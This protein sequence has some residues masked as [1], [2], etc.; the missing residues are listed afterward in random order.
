MSQDS[1]KIESVAAREVLDS[2]G[3]PTVEAEVVLEGGARACGIAPSGASTGSGEAV[4]L[5]DGDPKRFGGKGVTKAV[6][7]ASGA[8]A[9][10]LVGT[11]AGDQVQVD[12]AMIE[13]DGTPDKSRLGANAIL[14]VSI[15]CARAAAAHAGKEPYET[16]AAEPDGPM[17][18]PLM[19]LIN[20]GAHASNALDFQ[21]FM[22]VPHGFAR[23]SDALRAGAEIYRCLGD[24]LSANGLGTTVGDE[25]GYA[26]ALESAEDALRLLE[27]SIGRAGY[28]PGE[29]V[30]LALDCAATE[31]FSGGGYRMGGRRCSSEEMVG[32]LCS[33][34]ER[35]PHLVSIEDGLAED[36]WEGWSL[37]TAKLGSSALLVGDDLFVTSADL[38][39]RGIR[40][41]AANAILVKPNQAGTL[42]ETA[43]VV[44]LAKS[45]GFASVMS[46]R[47]G[48]TEDTTIADLAV[49]WG[50]GKIKAGAP[51]RTDRTAKYNRLLR[52]EAETGRPL[53]AL[54]G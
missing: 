45:A 18:I 52:I 20:G 11:P 44:A 43:E 29:E 49:A 4:E 19:N 9:G 39:R 54:K 23:F 26:P 5:R 46:H 13:L 25:G 42:T 53:A 24:L 8:I 32:L 2:R 27:E 48:E 40:E 7:N 30:G 21:E 10:A 36:D 50:T 12:R 14:A 6:Q 37:L 41:K 17:P 35:F 15:A 3:N 34:A 38:L 16:L 31:L 51:C 28:R 47:S 33:L 1:G 22:V